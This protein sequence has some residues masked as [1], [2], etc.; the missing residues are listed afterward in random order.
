ME[1]YIIKITKKWKQKVYISRCPFPETHNFASASQT[2]VVELQDWVA[3]REKEQ[4]SQM[5]TSDY[6]KDF[7]LKSRMCAGWQ[8]NLKFKKK[9]VCV[10]CIIP[11]QAHR[12]MTGSLSGLEDNLVCVTTSR[13]FLAQRRLITQYDNMSP[14]SFLPLSPSQNAPNTSNEQ[15]GKEF[16]DS[17]FH[18]SFSCRL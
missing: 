1:P 4:E 8:P 17:L 15:R 12:L 13:R 6:I 18:L 2:T 9:A 11:G 16:N 5:W 10:V 7:H 3:H 14:V